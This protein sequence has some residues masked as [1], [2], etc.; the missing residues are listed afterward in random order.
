MPRQ[1]TDLLDMFRTKSARA[2]SG[3]RAVSRP[4]A[5]EGKVIVLGRRQILLG[6]SVLALFVALAFVAGVAV[7]RSK[8]PASDVTLVK[9]AQRPSVPSSV[10]MLRSRAMPRL[11]MGAENL[12]QKAIES[13]GERF[14][15]LAPFLSSIPVDDGKGKVVA[16]QFA[17]V[18]KGFETRKMAD[19]W[20]MSL[21]VW[22][23]EGFLPFEASRAYNAN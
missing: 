7:G 11:G 15:K 10:W 4:T 16:G 14:P 12:E 6:G 17:L 2:G 22:E 21:S 8:G 23:I 20:R 5:G 9:P 1:S 19:D 13:F 3:A 18:L